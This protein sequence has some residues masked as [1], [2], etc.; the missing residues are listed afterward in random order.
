MGKVY[1]SLK[2]VVK[3]QRS[4]NDPAAMTVVKHTHASS[5]D[6]EINALVH[7]IK[8]PVKHCEEEIEKETQQVIR[9]LSEDFTMLKTKLKDAE[10]TVR[11]EE[12]ARQKAEESLTAK[13]HDLQNELNTEKETLQSRDNEINDLK[14]NVDV[15]VKQ[16]TE[17][18]IAIKQAKAEVA[19]EANRVEQL[20]E[21]SNTKIAASESQI[22][23]LK[24]IVRGKE[25][26]IQGLEQNL[27]AK[28]QRFENELKNKE[29]LLA[30]RDVEIND[31][32]SQLKLLT[33]LAPDAAQEEIVSP[34]L[35][36]RITDELTEAMNVIG[37]IASIIVRDH[38]VALGESVKTFPKSRLPE[39]LDSL[40]KEIANEPLRIG[41]RKRFV[42]HV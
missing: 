27:T 4:K 13:I 25:S 2:Q 24:E 32:K 3:L 29:K 35:F 10:E 30:G 11:R 41:F 17:L 28:S 14:S 31:L 34:E 15:L 12:S 23:D 5:F 37:R 8:A 36:Q 22:R 21:S 18:G 40:S 7:R 9:T 16:V 6:E 19:T 20:T 33:K 26:T 39:L 42:K 1:K 38:V